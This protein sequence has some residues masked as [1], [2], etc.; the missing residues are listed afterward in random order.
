M[1]NAYR[2][3]KCQKKTFIVEVAYGGVASEVKCR[4]GC[5]EG[6]AIGMNYPKGIRLDQA[7]WEWY[8]PGEDEIELLNPASAE[9]VIKGGLLVR[10][11]KAPNIQPLT[12][13]EWKRIRNAAAS[14]PEQARE[15]V[16]RI[17]VRQF[18]EPTDAIKLAHQEA[19]ERFEAIE[20][21]VG[22]TEI[23]KLLEDCGRQMFER[24]RFG[25][26]MIMTE[27]VKHLQAEKWSA[28][29]E[30][31][32]DPVQLLAAVEC[33]LKAGTPWAAGT[34][35]PIESRWPFTGFITFQVDHEDPAGHLAAAGAWLAVLMDV[36]QSRAMQEAKRNEEAKRALEQ[37]LDDGEDD[38]QEGDGPGS[39]S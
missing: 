33:H 15:M 20:D 2:C 10:A 24:D 26:M 1:V 6:K 3:E 25:A 13:G 9:R 19:R 35:E 36:L 34:L 18:R 7:A 30:D 12:W 28:E 23:M 39:V 22:T 14:A 16:E 4:D 31:G 11:R 29:M 27:R 21:Q 37:S 8:R 5:R 32:M 38:V 17:D